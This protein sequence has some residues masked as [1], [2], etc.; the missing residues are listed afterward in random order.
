M[1][2]REPRQPWKARRKA[3]DPVVEMGCGSGFVPERPAVEGRVGRRYAVNGKPAREARCSA[4][5]VSAAAKSGP[6]SG[7]Y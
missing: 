7:K 5:I 4:N 6:P 3:R 1:A 2:H